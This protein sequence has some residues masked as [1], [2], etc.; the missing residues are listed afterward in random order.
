M[1]MPEYGHLQ[2][3]SAMDIFF[4]TATFSGKGDFVISSS[5]IKKG[6]PIRFGWKWMA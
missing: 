1:R 2:S 5:N 4:I 3:D 6:S